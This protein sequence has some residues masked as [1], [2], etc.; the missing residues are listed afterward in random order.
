[1][2]AP[3][4]SGAR[5]ATTARPDELAEL[6]HGLRADLLARG[7]FLPTTWVEESAADLR[8][9]RLAGWVAGG[10]PPTALA[11]FTPRGAR[12]YA[13]AHVAAGPDPVAR[14]LALVDRLVAELPGAVARAD[15]G[16]TGLTE[17]EEDALARRLGERAGFSVLARRAM[18]FSLSSL[19]LG[20]PPVP[21]EGVQRLRVRDVPIDA[22]AALDWVGFQGTSDESLVADT[23]EE[24]RTVVS[25]I[26]EGRLGLFLDDAST[27]LVTSQGHL[28]G[29]LLT[30]EQSPRRSVFLDLVV[31]PAHRRRK[32]GHYLVLFGLRAARA[33]GYVDVRLW[34]TETNVPARTLYERE[35]FRPSLRALIYRF[36]REAPAGPPQPQREA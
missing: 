9:G 6:T 1:M 29:I 23:V 22:I 16:V 26:V 33:L 13:H 36:S 12:A 8:S 10:R 2:A 14:A 32:L 30:A 31:H 3:G 17:A 21:P 7:E 5:P 18:D 24:D 4:E 19:A 11:F 15:L 27:A 28:V 35:G 20:P 25:E 34:V